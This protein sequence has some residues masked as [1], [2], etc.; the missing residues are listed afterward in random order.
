MPPSENMHTH[1]RIKMVMQQLFS[2]LE[3]ERERERERSRLVV[4][5]EA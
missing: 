1:A 4:I 2:V 5:P 3:R